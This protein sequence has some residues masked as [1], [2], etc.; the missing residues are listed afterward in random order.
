M[1]DEPVPGRPSSIKRAFGAYANREVPAE[2]VR[3]THV[4]PGTPCGEY[5]RRF[6]Q[7]VGH[8]KDLKDLPVPIRI[9]GED[10]VLFR[11]RAGRVGLLQRQCCHRGTSLEFGLIAER[12]IRCC[13]HGWLFDVDGTILET[14]AEPETSR[15]KD[16]L[17]QG[18]YPTR[19]YSGLVFAY[20]GP[21]EPPPPFPQLDMFEVPGY[22][23]EPGDPEQNI[24]PCNWLQVQDNVLDIGHETFLHARSSGLQINDAGGRPLAALADL[25]E[26]DFFETPIGV[27]CTSTRRVGHSIWVRGLEHI[28]PN[29]AQIPRTP[30]LPPA[31]APGTDRITVRP[32]ATRWRVPVDDYHTLELSLVRVREGEANTY[33]KQA[34]L[35]RRSN[36]GD[37][38]FEERQ[39]FPGDYDAQVSQRAI[40]RHGLEHLASTDRGVALFRRQLRRGIDA[41]AEGKE[42]AESLRAFPARTYGFETLVRRSPANDAAADRQLLHDT[43]RRLVEARLRG[44]GSD[45]P[46]VI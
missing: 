22:R 15:L 12:G 27:L 24:K 6:W 10:L 8:T 36:Y 29:I 25:P 42:P 34:S 21:S 45:L 23:L 41:V 37:R 14:P 2:D 30:A 33:S 38:P 9:M 4:G 26:L 20:M 31:Y 46:V 13:Y 5:L 11:D 17:F 44:E 1:S 39:R 19:E 7:P 32:R 43:T 16:L 18:A 35:A 40:A 3:L 28:A